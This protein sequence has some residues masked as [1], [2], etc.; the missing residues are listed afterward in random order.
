[1]VGRMNRGYGPDKN[2]NDG[3]DAKRAKADLG[4]LVDEF[5]PVHF[6]I[7]RFGEH[8][9]DHEEITAYIFEN[10]HAVI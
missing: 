5:L 9:F 6:S 1:M 2:G 7:L 10:G 3:H 8:S 4:A